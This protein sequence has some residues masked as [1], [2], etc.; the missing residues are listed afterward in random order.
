MFLA[1]QLDEDGV[2]VKQFQ[3]S[4][5]IGGFAV[6]LSNGKAAFITA[7]TLKFDPS[8]S[9]K[10]QLRCWKQSTLN[11]PVSPDM[12]GENFKCPAKG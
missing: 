3:Y 1:S 6:V 5:L 7:N 10:Y 11:P 8:V 12:T 4:P 9:T 2:Y